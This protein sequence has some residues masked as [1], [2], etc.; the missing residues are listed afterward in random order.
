MSDLLTPDD[1]PDGF[2]YPPELLRL[3]EHGIV[4]LEPWL[5]LV[6][7]R[8][9]RRFEGLGQRYPHRALVPFAM[10]LDN[11]DVATFEVGSTGVTIVHDFASP[12]YEQ[13]ETYPDVNAWLRKAIDD[14]IEF[15]D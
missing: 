1:L 9:R 5:V 6:G 8:L 11:D 13:R 3:V 7:E 14:Y 4:D 15:D 10:R 12:G 2:T